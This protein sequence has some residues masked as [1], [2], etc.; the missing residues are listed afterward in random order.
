MEALSPEM[1]SNQIVEW[2]PSEKYDLTVFDNEFTLTNEQ[3]S[4]G[5]DEKGDDGKVPD[6]IGL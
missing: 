2:S 4:E 3:K 1:L 5:K 6:W